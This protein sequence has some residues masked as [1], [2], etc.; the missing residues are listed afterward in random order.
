MSASRF[1]IVLPENELIFWS[2]LVSEG[3]GGGVVQPLG[4]GPGE[5][6]PSAL[7]SELIA[8]PDSNPM[9]SI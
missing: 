7:L 5:T 4:N 3:K 9:G 8:Y 2:R 6:N 1:H